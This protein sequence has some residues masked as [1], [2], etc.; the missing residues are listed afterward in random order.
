[1]SRKREPT[2]WQGAM[3]DASEDFYGFLYR[4]THKETG[5]WYIGRKSLVSV[6]RKKVPGQTR[7]KVEKKESDWRNY[8]SSSKELQAWIDEEGLDAFEFIILGYCTHRSSLR[9]AETYLLVTTH[10]LLT[11]ESLNGQTDNLRGRMA[12]FCTN[13]MEVFKIYMKGGNK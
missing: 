6:R 10:A 3:E 12:G 1:M 11:D 7:R 2:P 9:Y 4:I 13:L 5:K 8:R